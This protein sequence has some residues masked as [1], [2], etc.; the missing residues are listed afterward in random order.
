MKLGKT[1]MKLLHAYLCRRKMEENCGALQ[2]LLDM[3][4]YNRIKPPALINPSVSE[5]R[6]AV[7][8]KIMGNSFGLGTQRV[9]D[10]LYAL[11][12]VW[13]KCC[14]RLV[15]CQDLLDDIPSRSGRRESIQTGVNSTPTETKQ[16][17]R[18]G[19]RHGTKGKFVIK[20]DV[21]SELNFTKELLSGVSLL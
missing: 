13:F 4:S 21:S 6:N 10:M 9:K 5:A 11:L 20:E 18:G 7:K 12:Y 19:A 8:W 2:N 1:L 3:R 16:P 17:G 14:F 15:G